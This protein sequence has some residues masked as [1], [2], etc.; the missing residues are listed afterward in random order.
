MAYQY[1]STT[2]YL[3]GDGIP[4]HLEVTIYTAHP[5]PCLMNHILGVILPSSR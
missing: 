1:D 2:P 4:L 3:T 5:T